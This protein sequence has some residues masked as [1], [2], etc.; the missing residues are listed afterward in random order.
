MHRSGERPTIGI[1]AYTAGA[2]DTFGGV[3]SHVAHFAKSLT[4]LGMRVVIHC[5]SSAGPPL[6]MSEG[7]V[8]FKERL[9]E[10]VPG[11]IAYHPL[12]GPGIEG[13]VDE[14]VAI[15]QAHNE[16]T[17]FCFGTHDGYVFD[18][19][20]KSVERLSVSLISFIYFTIEERWFRSF[21]RSRTR[22]IAGLSSPNERLESFEYG[23]DIVARVVA[24]SRRVVVPTHYVRAQILAIAGVDAAPK[25]TVCYHGV[26]PELFSPSPTQPWTPDRNLLVVARLSI[27]FACHKG[28]LWAAR[29]FS[30]HRLEMPGHKLTFCGE[31]N[32]QE[33]LRAFA[34]ERGISDRLEVAGFL[35]Q[36]S[37]AQRYRDSA[38][39]LVP[40]M[41][42]A[43]ST[44]VVEAVLCGCLPVALD[45]TGLAEVMHS[46]G[47]EAYCVPG[48]IE[49]MGADVMTVVPNDE[50]VLATLRRAADHPEIV[51]ADLAR[52]RQIALKR[53]S[54]TRTTD[55]I[56]ETLGSERLF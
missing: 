28:F 52:A 16:R 48:Q 44:T 36:Q 11:V 54:I 20:I 23:G 18:I 6:V 10:A 31:G 27:P 34:L 9:S 43:G 14:N 19:A 38:F 49:E 32:G 4:R 42:E 24:A 37:L 3:E 40:S 55:R 26:D 7:R 21:F 56:L 35:D 29:F 12:H 13:A 47:L 33:A 46:L 5:L 22:S 30:E 2:A 51:R 8:H 41:M 17:I 50:A 25:T 53:F 1:Y 45:A 39:L 15:S